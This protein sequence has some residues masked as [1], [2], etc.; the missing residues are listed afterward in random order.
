MLEAQQ[1]K[2]LIAAGLPC[3]GLHVEGDGNYPKALIVSSQFVGK[4][5]VQRQQMVNALLRPHFDSGELHSLTMQ[6]MTPDEWTSAR[7]AGRG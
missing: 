5:R 3:E 4:S 7:E 2:Q 1:I 6:T